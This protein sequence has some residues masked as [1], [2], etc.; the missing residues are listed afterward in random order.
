[1]LDSATELDDA[2]ADSIEA[3]D[4]IDSAACSGNAEEVVLS[5][6]T[7]VMLP[8]RSWLNRLSRFGE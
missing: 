6:D 4:L 5:L 1:M 3:E 2:V 8:G 7:E